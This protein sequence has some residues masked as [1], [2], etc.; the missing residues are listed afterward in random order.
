MEKRYRLVSDYGYGDRTWISRDLTEEQA[1]SAFQSSARWQS[2]P[3]L[4]DALNSE[5]IYHIEEDNPED[6][7]DWDWQDS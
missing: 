4:Q 7:E 3:T 6:V 5:G 1:I 2:K